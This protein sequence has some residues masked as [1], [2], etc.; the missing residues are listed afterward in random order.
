MRAVHDIYLVPGFF[1][2]ANLGK[3][4]YFGHLRPLLLEGAEARGVRAN[5]HVVR[6]HPT[7]SLTRRAA[8]LAEAIG[9]TASRGR[10]PIHLVGHSSGGMD[11]R[12]FLSP[13]V[14][15][16]TGLDVDRLA[17]R[18]ET[19]VT[20]STPHRGT[21]LAGFLAS[22]LGQQVLQAI[23]ISTIY[24]LRYGRIPLQPML[25]LSAAIAE[26]DTLVFD[27]NLLHQVFRSVLGDF[28]VGR[29][30]AVS[31]LF[32]QVAS[33][34]SLLTQ[35]TPAAIDVF[36]ATVADRGSVRYGSVVTRS[37][38][39]GVHSVVAAGLDPAA[40]AIHTVYASLYRL[41]SATRKE[42]VPQLPAAQ[43]RALRTAYRKVPGAGDNDGIVPTLSQAW[44][45]VIDA[46]TAD[47]LDV[48]GHF[49]DPQARPRHIDWI[50]TGSGF[51][52]QRYR[53]LWDRVLDF[54]LA[55]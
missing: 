25:Q 39:P 35:L 28:S 37:V 15:L 10:G 24:V 30:R 12:L 43:L 7:A 38:A 36:N 4:T 20:I 42:D 40:Q 1:G 54:V 18:V 11:V 46:V 41:A 21:P 23:S 26:A 17:R 16:P 51:S 34:Q 6:T 32:A 9:E 55:E 49:G 45:R 44:G 22:R 3:L 50:P 2:F 19:A 48:I 5:V 13:G 8:L 14:S 52:R 31:R 27:S 47:H 33:D 53:K 29:R